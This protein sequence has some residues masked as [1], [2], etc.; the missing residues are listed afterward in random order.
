MMRHPQGFSLVEALM[1]VAVIAAMTGLFFDSV[2]ISGF[3]GQSLA[4]RRE[5]VLLAQSLLDQAQVSMPAGARGEAGSWHGLDWHVTR[6]ASGGGARASGPPLELVRIE[7]AERGRRL[8][9]V[10]TLRLKR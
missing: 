5:A 4:R 6:R 9:S 2:G 3:M 1:A 8:A 10:Q 7:I